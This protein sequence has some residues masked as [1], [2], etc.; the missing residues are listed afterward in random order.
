MQ[1][2]NA[3]GRRIT[4]LFALVALLAASLPGLAVVFP[5]TAATPEVAGNCLLSMFNQTIPRDRKV[6]KQSH[7][8]IH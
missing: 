1:A 2:S 7:W 4:M 8:L 6:C 5:D 3:V